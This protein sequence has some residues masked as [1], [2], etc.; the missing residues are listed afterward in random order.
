MFRPRSRMEKGDNFFTGIMYIQY[1]KK[2]IFSAD[3]KKYF[4]K[5]YHSLPGNIFVSPNNSRNKINIFKDN[6]NYEEI[7]KNQ[8]CSAIDDAVYYKDFREYLDIFIN[9]PISDALNHVNPVYKMLAILD[10]RVGKRTLVKLLHSYKQEPDW[11][12]EIYLIRFR[13]EGII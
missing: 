5:N 6:Y 1:D 4:E 8:V 10:R 11:L 7:T 2:I 9:L 3:N 13:S 12:Q